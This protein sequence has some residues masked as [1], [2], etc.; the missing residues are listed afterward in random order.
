[1][2]KIEAFSNEAIQKLKVRLRESEIA[3]EELTRENE[4]LKALLNEKEK[5]RKTNLDQY[6]T[7]AQKF[8]VK[9]K[10]MEILKASFDQSSIRV[11]RPTLMDR[12][13]T[14]DHSTIDDGPNTA[15]VPNQTI[16]GS[17]SL[18]NGACTFSKDSVPH[19][20]PVMTSNTYSSLV[21]S[22][23]SFII[24]GVEDDNFIIST[25]KAQP[26]TNARKRRRST[27]SWIPTHFK[28]YLCRKDG[29]EVIAYDRIDDYR[30]HII[31]THPKYRFLCEKC[32]YNSPSNI[33]LQKHKDKVIHKD[34]A[35]SS[36]N[37]CYKPAHD[38]SLCGIT[39]NKQFLLK[40]HIK[41]YH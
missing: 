39:Y 11:D 9:L 33:A 30:D 35:L 22:D 38:C 1:M 21:I 32:P 19:T 31:K 12:S 28:C 8:E 7:F 10:E 25:P 23:E 2:K 3:N 6:K 36:Q 34:E 40:Q 16:M 29:R 37:S 18:E 13:T 5:E 27:D 14:L 4:N 26:I 41:L 15:D 20:V 17:E 24:D